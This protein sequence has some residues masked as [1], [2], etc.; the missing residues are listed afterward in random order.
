MDFL[1]D[2]VKRIWKVLYGAGQ[3]VKEEF[4][5]L[6]N[7]KYPDFPEELKFLHAEE[8]LEMYPDLPRKQ[9]ETKYIVCFGVYLVLYFA[10]SFLAFASRQAHSCACRLPNKISRA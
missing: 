8:I 9:R 1:K 6:R 5:E 2:I 7:S 10:G 3:M 4:P